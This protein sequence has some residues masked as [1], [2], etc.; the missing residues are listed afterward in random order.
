MSNARDFSALL[1]RVACV[2]LVVVSCVGSEPTASSGSSGADGGTSNGDDAGDAAGSGNPARDTGSTSGD[3][4]GG[5]TADS[6]V[7][8]KYVF[9]SSS[10]SN[11]AL[12]GVSGADGVCQDLATKAHLPGTYKAWIS[13]DTPQSSP[14]L[15]F[16]QSQ[17]PYVRVDGRRVADSWTSLTMNGL[18]NPINVTEQGQAL[19]AGSQYVWTDT[20]M[21][22]TNFETSGGPTCGHWADATNTNE[23]NVGDASQTNDAWTYG[24]AMLG[25]SNVS[26]RLYCFQ[27]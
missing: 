18:L 5:T 23:I 4:G 21:A 6:A 12:G 8:G 22:G 24:T 11:A 14:A 10:Q 9:L 2:A 1:A 25:C 17:I 3:D 20:V 16:T 13:D 15:R 26:G 7:S 27:Q 19:D